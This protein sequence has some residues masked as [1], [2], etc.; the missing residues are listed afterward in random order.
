MPA[1]KQPVCGRTSNEKPNCFFFQA[2]YDSCN[3]ASFA[4]KYVSPKYYLIK[5]G[6]K[7]LKW[8]G[9]NFLLLQFY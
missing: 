8:T 3:S 6:G 7:D 2:N 5:R 1:M 4:S 9:G